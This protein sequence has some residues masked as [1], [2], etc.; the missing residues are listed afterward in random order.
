[1]TDAEARTWVAEAVSEAFFKEGV[2]PVTIT[3]Q[4]SLVK[5]VDLIISSYLFALHFQGEKAEVVQ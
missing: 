1:M 5:L 4:A 3:E 2:S